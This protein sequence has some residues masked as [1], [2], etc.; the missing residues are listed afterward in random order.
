M[1]TRKP[2]TITSGKFI[3]LCC[4]CIMAGSLEQ[5]RPFQGCSIKLTA[6]HHAQQIAAYA[7]ELGITLNQEE[8]H[9]AA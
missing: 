3:M 6:P 4:R 8:T 5:L 2:K 1:A 7:G 9:D